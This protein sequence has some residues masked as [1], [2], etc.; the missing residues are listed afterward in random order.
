MD[1]NAT[2]LARASAR[3]ERAKDTRASARVEL[4]ARVSSNNEGRVRGY[5][6]V[7]VE[8]DQSDLMSLL[9]MLY[10]ELIHIL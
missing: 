3:D 6:L 7:F 9:V 4:I 10:F 2:V 5:G 8:C 1:R